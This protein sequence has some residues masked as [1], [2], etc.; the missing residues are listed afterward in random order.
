VGVCV[1]ACVCVWVCVCVCARACVSILPHACASM[2]TTGCPLAAHNSF[3]RV[4]HDS[5]SMCIR[6]S[7]WFSHLD[8]LQ[9]VRKDNRNHIVFPV[10]ALGVVTNMVILKPPKLTSDGTQAADRP[11][12]AGYTVFGERGPAS[13]GAPSRAAGAW[14]RNGTTAADL[15][16]WLRDLQADL[17]LTIA[18]VR[19]F[20]VSVCG[21]NNF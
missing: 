3:S 7:G 1:C 6:A 5:L 10:Q 17:L 20:P 4:V 9:N 8:N 12:S 21:K 14:V 18:V 11:S 2:R 15:L 19:A 16:D 13:L